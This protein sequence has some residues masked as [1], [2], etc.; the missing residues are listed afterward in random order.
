MSSISSRRATPAGSVTFQDALDLHRGDRLEEAK[1]AYRSV[2]A[3]DPR[4]ADA[5][6]LLGV[7][8][9]QSGSAEEGILALTRALALQPRN[10]T[11]LY[12][13][14]VACER[15]GRLEESQAAHARALGVDPQS[16]VAWSARAGALR[17]LGRWEEAVACC[18]K[19]V[20]LAPGDAEAWNDLGVALEKSGD[21][22]GAG[23]AYGR[24]VVQDAGCALAV[25]NLA[26]F[27]ERHGTSD[28][29]L[30]SEALDLLWRHLQAAPGD[31]TRW[32][33]FVEAFRSVGVHDA[34]AAEH[35]LPVLV[36]CLSRDGVDH[37]RLTRVGLSILK[38]HP[39]T[40]PL[41][42][43]AVDG[44][45]AV[46]ALLARDDT[47]A[48]LALPAIRLL[49]ERTVV[50]DATW[51]LLFTRARRHL[52]VERVARAG[53]EPLPAGMEE[54]ALAIARQCFQNGYVWPWDDAETAAVEGLVPTMAGRRL[55]ADPGDRPKVAVLAS[56]VP[57][58]EWERAAEVVAWADQVG[59]EP[60]EHLVRQQIREP[61]Q[62]ESL[63]EVIPSFGEL[64]TRVSAEV[65]EMYEEHP[66]PRW[67][68]LNTHTPRPV[69]D[70][71]RSQFPWAR[72]DRLAGVDR[73]R[74]LVAGC[75]TGQHLLGVAGRF[76]GA[77]VTGVDLS[78]SSLAY[79]VRKAAELGFEDVS[80]VQADILALD[81]WTEPFH[82]IECA[83]VLH[84]ME[85]PMA[86][87]SVLERLL[88]PGG[89]M[90]IGL[91]SE[92]ARRSVV[93]ARAYIA[94]QGWAATPEDIR[95]ARPRI[96][97]HFAETDERSPAR[98]RDFFNMHECRDL[99]FH[100]Q[101]HR[102]TIPRIA[103]ALDSLGLTFVGWDGLPG[104]VLE[105]FRERFP[106]PSDH[107]SLEAWH[108]F[109][110]ENPDTF[111]SMYQFWIWKPVP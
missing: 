107:R 7:A 83:G 21:P 39:R 85:D 6:A 101:E 19:A 66:Y 78:R 76:Q 94:E 102:F 63:K 29:H 88:V 51:E 26:S 28:P 84:H 45:E 46:D 96:A 108:R 110:T 22:S 25:T 8:L 98:W 15:A 58:L 75:G 99:L 34:A 48:A 3:R 52:A 82:V 56:Y 44:E 37:R 74:V 105:A 14:G 38:A 35:L 41:L 93:E 31:A 67:L 59:D 95:A 103:N 33:T 40:A 72:T 30:A 68:S 23:T 65:Q 89:F 16:R 17:S 49:L 54:A 60:L 42:A 81:A 32:T 104:T 77:E 109:E 79:A 1:S 5:T 18:R 9:V 36:A 87:W 70:S 80:V 86:G 27:L 11:F 13:L 62:E 12:N 91:Y 73:P 10:P 69:A 55:G 100:V 53:A 97:Q 20:E 47:W 90:K 92:A 106:E 50:P 2:L 4:N 111:S 61:V 71:L 57:L 43:A 64:A 24:A